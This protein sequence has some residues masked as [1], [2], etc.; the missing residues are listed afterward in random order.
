MLQTPAESVVVFPSEL[1]W[2]FLT[3]SSHSRRAGIRRLSFGHSVKSAALE[4]VQHGSSHHAVT[5]ITESQLGDWVDLLQYYAKGE[6]VDLSCIPVALDQ[7]TEFEMAVR[8]A[9]QHIPFGQTLTY[10]ELAEQVGRPGAARAVGN[11]MRKNPTPLVVPCHRVVGTQGLGGFSAPQGLAMKTRLLDL[12]QRSAGVIKQNFRRH[13][14]P[15]SL[16]PLVSSR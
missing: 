5:T 13:Q 9:C 1:G 15:R 4:A 12:E 10:G 3:F 8:L 6:A 16:K 14:L 2:M 7:F 11:V